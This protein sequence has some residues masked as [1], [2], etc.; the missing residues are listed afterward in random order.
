[1]VRN[2]W[3]VNC[4]D[5]A[6]RKRDLTVYVNEGQI[7]IVAPPGETAVLAPLEVGRLRA[8]LRDAVVTASVASRE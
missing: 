2:Q 8:A 3:S 4:R 5:V 6:G 7:V 1:M